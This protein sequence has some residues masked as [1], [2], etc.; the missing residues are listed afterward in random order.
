[1]CVYQLH[2][3]VDK[4]HP[5]WRGLQVHGNIVTRA[6]RDAVPRLTGLHQTV[7]TAQAGNNNREEEGAEGGEGGET[8]K[9]TE[10]ENKSGFLNNVTLR[11]YSVTTVIT[12]TLKRGLPGQF[13]H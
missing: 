6:K 1:M 5:K 13:W 10:G 8:E 11:I 3:T 9:E 4:R 12:A 7:E 2:G